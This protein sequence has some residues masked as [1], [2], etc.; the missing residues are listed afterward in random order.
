[1]LRIQESN[2]R[3]KC[4]Y[5]ICVCVKERYQVYDKNVGIKYML[6]MQVL[7]L[8]LEF[9]YVKNVGI[10]YM[11]QECKFQINVKNVVMK[12]VSSK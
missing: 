8:C 3:K 6:G 10:K 12:Q 5:Q 4:R 7:N 9:R 1:M 2:M 11:L